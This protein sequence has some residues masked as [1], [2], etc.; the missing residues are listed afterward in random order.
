MADLKDVFSK[1]VIAVFEEY[2]EAESIE[3]RETLPTTT[4]MFFAIKKYSKE[5]SSVQECAEVYNTLKKVLNKHNIGAS[6]MNE[7]AKLMQIENDNKYDASTKFDYVN[8][9]SESYNI[10]N[11]MMSRFKDT[12]KKQKLS[13]ML[14]CIF[15]DKNHET[16]LFNF[17]DKVHMLQVE[18]INNGD[19]K[20]KGK[21]AFTIED[22]YAD[23]LKEIKSLSIKVSGDNE[24]EKL[25]WI[26]NVNKYVT[27]HPQHTIG[28]ENE[29]RALTL[30]LTCRTKKSSLLIGPAG[31]GKTQTVYELA[32]RINNGTADPLLLKK[33]IFELSISAITAGASMF[34]Q[35]EN[36]VNS[37]IDYLKEHQDYIL[38]IDEF[39]QANSKVN[40]QCNIANMMKPFIGRGEITVVGATTNDEFN[41][42]TNEDKA[43]SRR[44]RKVNVK[45]PSR[46]ETIAILNCIKPVNDEFFTK[47][48]KE[49]LIYKI[50]DLSYKYN[51][52]LANPDKSIQL[53]ELAYA[54][55]RL[56]HREDREI[57]VDDLINAVAYQY[58]IKI[59]KN[60]ALTT[61]KSLKE[62]LLGQDEALDKI[63]KNLK[64]V[65]RGVVDKNRP[66]SVMF[67]V[68]PTG[69]GK[70]EAA[71]IIARTFFGQE[72]ALVKINCNEYSDQLGYSKLVGSSAGFV[73]YNDGTDLINS[74]KRK[75]ACV[76]LFDEIEKAHPSVFK[77]LLSILDEGVM[78]DAKGDAI[79]FKNTI[80]IFTSN[81]GFSDNEGTGS[82]LVDEVAMTEKKLREKLEKVFA[83]E[84]IGRLND[85]IMF[86]ALD[87][88]ISKTLIDRYRDEFAANSETS[89]VFKEE[90]Y[91]AIIKNANIKKLGARIVKDYTRK[92]YIDVLTKDETY[93]EDI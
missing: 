56:A 25:P 32:Q 87:K 45:E 69:T 40:E 85:L 72:D 77:S 61:E 82:S 28:L 11:M 65:E 64:A 21:L 17:F 70:T 18:K 68:G 9:A 24:L 58:N 78:K 57:S 50:V 16:N 38:F 83:P 4:S 55:A 81:I 8:P 20:Y 19:E 15:D 90:D 91:E 92:Q 1:E 71:K 62:T 36:R 84:F 49:E 10:I 5:K 48:M 42:F 47:E 79:S 35:L 39:H 41:K 33:T 23:I 54:E 80:I 51:L 31:T 86:K 44:F 29:I 74:V 6:I 46:E 88:A 30:C 89:V 22:L 76:V 53:F 59:I 12:S 67:F 7:A 52:E 93:E 75:P 13:D 43:W 37:L 66:Q 26:T 27:L 73:G 3:L 14:F 60:K 34:G 63:V 2:L